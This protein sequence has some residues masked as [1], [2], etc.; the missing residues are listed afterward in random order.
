M[1]GL[2]M[3]FSCMALGLM[4]IPPVLAADYDLVIN[5]GRVMDPETGFDAAAN[6]GVKDGRIAVITKDEITG[7]ETI[8]AAGLVVAPGFIDTHFHYPRPMG[9]KLALR[10]GRTTVLDLEVGTLGTYMDQWYK[11][12]E[13]KNQTNYGAASAHELAR[14]LVLDGFEAHDTPEAVKSRAAGTGWSSKRPNLEEGNKILKILDEGLAAG[15]LGIGSTLGYMRAGVSAREVF[16]I[17]KVAGLYGRQ[18][19]TPRETTP[20]RP[21]ASRKCSPCGGAGRPGPG[22]PLQQPRLQSG[23][24]TAGPDAG[25]RDERLG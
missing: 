3:L 16:E 21:T 14:S 12:R 15:G 4:L 5:N 22:L 24:R 23:A 10:D 7:K 9:E 17:Q 25:A 13:G 19:G 18:C 6:V 20:R 8:D 2:A 1:K 11:E